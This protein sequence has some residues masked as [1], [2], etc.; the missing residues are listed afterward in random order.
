MG[1]V[2]RSQQ[3]TSTKKPRA[4]NKWQKTTDRVTCLFFF[5]RLMGYARRLWAVRF[6]LRFSDLILFWENIVMVFLSFSYREKA[7]NEKTI[8]QIEEKKR[9]EKGFFSQLFW[10][11]VFDMDFPQ[12]AWHS[13]C[14]KTQKGHNK[15]QKLKKFKKYLPTPLSGY[16][17]D[18]RS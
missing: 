15:S 11:K 9:Q 12:N 14:W 2:G 5:C 17:P 6:V 4:Q 18:I 8:N 16:L 7:K 13:P 1:Q 3:G 10:K